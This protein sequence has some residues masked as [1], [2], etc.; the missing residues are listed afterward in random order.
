MW[1]YARP[2][3]GPEM[4][5]WDDEILYVPGLTRDGYNTYSPIGLHRETLGL[6]KATEVFGAKFFGSGA[7][8]SGYVKHPGKISKEA[9]TRIKEQMEEKH[10]GLELSHRIMVLEEGMSFDAA[11]IAPEDAQFLQTRQFQRAE[12]AGLFRVPPHKIGDLSRATFSNIEQQDLE[13]LRDCIAPWLERIEQACNRV[14]LLPN[15]KG[16]IYIEFEIKGML[17]GDTAARAAW[18]NSRFN[19]ASMNPNEIR[20]CENE[21]PYDGGDEYFA[22]MNVVPVAL[23]KKVHVD[24]DDEDTTE[25]PLQRAVKANQRFFRDAMGRVL[26][27]KPEERARFGAT[28]FLQPVLSVVECCLVIGDGECRHATVGGRVGGED[29]RAREGLGRRDAGR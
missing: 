7:H 16:R 18:Y 26:K 24:E 1:F 11:Q 23:L 14:L 20:E 29:G 17:R 28:A 6:S 2:V 12:V 4:K 5:Y 15:E 9:Q 10:S 19:T 21:E 22:P 27:R 25:D 13:F 3:N 8:P